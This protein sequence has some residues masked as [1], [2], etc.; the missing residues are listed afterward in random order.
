MAAT[1]RPGRLTWTAATHSFPEHLRRGVL[2][3]LTVKVGHLAGARGV[4]V[5]GGATEARLAPVQLGNLAGVMKGARFLA[6]LMPSLR[7]IDESILPDAIVLTDFVRARLAQASGPPSPIGARTAA[8]ALF[9]P[10]AE[11]VPRE[12]KDEPTAPLRGPER[13][14]SDGGGEDRRDEN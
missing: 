12:V 10:E 4:R 1:R 11:P 13:P 7:E 6:E 5:S 3:D 9:V 2:C 8:L 14:P